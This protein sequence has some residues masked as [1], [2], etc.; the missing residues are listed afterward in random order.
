MVKPWL[1]PQFLV[2][3]DFWLLEGTDLRPFENTLADS[4]PSTE[5]FLDHAKGFGMQRF[6]RV[7]VLITH[8]MTWMTWMYHDV[9]IITD[10]ILRCLFMD[11]HMNDN[12]MNLFLPTFFE[13]WK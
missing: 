6:Y 7:C 10:M 8:G 11:Y 5:V 2:I 9:L 4:S 1:N 12:P 13:A 3:P